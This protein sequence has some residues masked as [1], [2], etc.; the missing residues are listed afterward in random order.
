MNVRLFMLVGMAAFFAA[1]WSSDRQ[2][3]DTQMA[4]ARE[5]RLQIVEFVPP[6]ASI[7]AD[8]PLATVSR[9]P[10]ETT[11]PF[12]A[13][14][15]MAANFAPTQTTEEREPVV[16][17]PAARTM[18]ATEAAPMQIMAVVPIVAQPSFRFDGP[19]L[20]DPAVTENTASAGDLA[21]DMARLCRWASQIRSEIDGQ[22]CWMR[23]QLRRT[24]YSAQRRMV[25][26]L[27]APQNWNVIVELL[28]RATFGPLDSP[29]KN[30][31][32]PLINEA[33]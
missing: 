17:P 7:P 32:A 5:A 2:Y 4:A 15:W 11:P 28:A 12:N 21:A 29:A 25:A 16:A 26:M 19:I 13:S 27:R 10:I 6:P 9:Q 8:E 30:A 14:A 22:T 18:I 20:N 1:L 24:S 31:A 3:Q 33:R 23:W